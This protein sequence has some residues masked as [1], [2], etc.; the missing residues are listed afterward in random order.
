MS[1]LDRLGTMSE[2]IRVVE[3]ILPAIRST[4]GWLGERPATQ[5]GQE[6]AALIQEL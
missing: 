5:R 1:P 3:M 4:F 2:Y 6:F